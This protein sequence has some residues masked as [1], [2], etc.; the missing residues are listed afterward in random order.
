[1]IPEY[2]RHLI[3]GHLLSPRIVVERMGKISRQRNSWI[4]KMARMKM[5]TMRTRTMRAVATE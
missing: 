2:W 5:K 4:Q 3:P 1:L